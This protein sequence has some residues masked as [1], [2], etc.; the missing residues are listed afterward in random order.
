MKKLILALVVLSAVLAKAQNSVAQT[1]SS[2]PEM[3]LT[4]A[5][6]VDSLSNEKILNLE[7]TGGG[8]DS[9]KHQT[10]YSLELLSKKVISK[11]ED[12]IRVIEA[13]VKLVVIPKPVGNC[14]MA[15]K[16][17]SRANLTQLLKAEGARL[18][19]EIAPNDP[20]TLISV[21][22]RVPPV[23]DRLSLSNLN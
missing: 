3:T 16:V 17:K 15:Y 19:L 7:Y 23:V 9:E 5:T 10:S 13:K 6:F 14:A 12:E 1:Q 21:E 18:G 20:G 8:C 11:P 22:F 2:G 4:S